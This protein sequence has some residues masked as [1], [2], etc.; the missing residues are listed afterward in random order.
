MFATA[1]LQ[2]TATVDSRSYVY[3]GNSDT[4]SIV[5]GTVHVTDMKPKK[6]NVTR[7]YAIQEAPKYGPYRAF[8]V[9]K[10]AEVGQETQ[11]AFSAGQASVGEVYEIRVH[12][13][14]PK[15]VRG[16]CN[17]TAGRVGKVVCVHVQVMTDLIE[18]GVV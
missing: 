5:E 1:T 4:T 2:K 17:C 11:S 10:D 12:A 9:M 8:Y 6:R 13:T 15:T 18:N 16:T 3:I 14:N 7:I